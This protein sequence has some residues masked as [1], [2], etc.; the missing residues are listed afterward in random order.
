M[1]EE[2][3]RK[4]DQALRRE[5]MKRVGLGIALVSLAGLYFVYTDLDAHIDNLRV[6]ATVTAIAPLNAKNTRMVEEGLAVEV[7]LNDGRHV[8]VMALKR[9]D[10]HIGDHVEI[11]EHRHHS[12]RVTY[13]WK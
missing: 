9:T 12:G 2:T 11:T 10:P 1:R 8:N 6:P 5:R 13:S 4:F 7:A 3:R